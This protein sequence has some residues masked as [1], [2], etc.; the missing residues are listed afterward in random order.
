[1]NLLSNINIGIWTTFIV[2]IRINTIHSYGFLEW[3]EAKWTTIVKVWILYTYTHLQR[4]IATGP[5][6]RSGRLPRS[7]MRGATSQAKLNSIM[8]HLRSLK[9]PML[10]ITR[11][12]I[13]FRF[14]IS[15]NSWTV[16]NKRLH[17]M[18][19]E[20]FVATSSPS[21]QC[22]KR[23]DWKTRRDQTLDIKS[24]I[25]CFAHHTFQSPSSILH[26]CIQSIRTVWQR[27]C[28]CDRY[29]TMWNCILRSF[30]VVLVNY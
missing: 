2:R 30:N 9:V 3:S 5:L 15:T 16:P 26:D 29:A 19:T 25:N 21:V 20:T 10:N 17:P 6:R 12:Q 22:S 7:K 18:L 1:M 28:K 13:S 14:K 23:K 4:Q 8:L 11:P 24:P 27:S